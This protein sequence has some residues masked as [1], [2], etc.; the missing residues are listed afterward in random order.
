[1]GA[2]NLK[3]RPT[4]QIPEQSSKEFLSNDQTSRFR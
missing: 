4:T 3:N 2:L 1:M